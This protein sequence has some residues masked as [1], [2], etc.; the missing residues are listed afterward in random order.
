MNQFTARAAARAAGLALALLALAF[1]PAPGSRAVAAPAHPA[2]PAAPAPARPSAQPGPAEL[3]ARLAQLRQELQAARAEL[4]TLASDTTL[5]TARRTRQLLRIEGRIRQLDPGLDSL[6]QRVTALPPGVR[7]IPNLAGLNPD[8]L[9]DAL[10]RQFGPML[11]MLRDRM[12]ESASQMMV[13]PT[14]P[15]VDWKEH[16][17]AAPLP[18]AASHSFVRALG[19]SP[20][21]RRVR[22]NHR[23][24]NVQVVTGTD[25]SIRFSVQVSVQGSM[26]QAEAQTL[27]DAVRLD[28]SMDTACT[29]HAVIPELRGLVDRAIRVDVTLELPRGMGASVRNA[30]GDVGVSGVAGPVDGSTAFGDLLAADLGGASR[31]EVR[32][33]DL[34]VERA[35]ASLELLDQFGM[36]VLRECAG[37]LVVDGLNSE[38]NLEG[39]RDG[40]RISARNGSLRLRNVVGPLNLTAQNASVGVESV[41]GAVN[42]NTQ[43][44]R[45]EL[46][47]VAG[48]LGAQCVDG[49]LSTSF[50]EQAQ[51]IQSRFCN[52]RVESPGGDVR[53]AGE[54][55]PLLLRLTEMAAG[56]RYD[57]TNR[58]GSVTLEVP[59]GGSAAIQAATNFG[60]IYSDVPVRRQDAGDWQ[61]AE[62][63]LGGGAAQISL[64]AV[65]SSIRI[66]TTGR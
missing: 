3:A 47:Q 12:G 64:Q 22:L 45:V 60:T 52:L 37:P 59:G 62:A 33:G 4:L 9:A 48:T 40:A 30:Y 49:S 36:L 18:T 61:R 39:V 56:R 2:R 42:L 1:M 17:G 53:V 14:L 20:D 15:W 27:A 51:D 58:Y 66:S 54:S 16:L 44:A 5:N 34:K 26:T 50:V 31:L 7:F 43:L 19:Q 41:R 24:G 57:A 35:R 10:A 65:N 13:H 46:T 8:S 38:M 25:D 32:N 11:R 21:V 28:I 6:D 63:T 23:F 55:A 29:A